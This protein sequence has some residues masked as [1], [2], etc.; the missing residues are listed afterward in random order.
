[1]AN[2]GS[3]TKSAAFGNVTLSWNVTSQDVYT[4]K[5]VVA[6]KLTIYRSSNISSSAPK[7]YSITFNDTVVKSGTNTIG[8]SGTKTLAEGSVTLTHLDNGTCS[9]TFGFSQDIEI[10]WSGKWNG[11]LTASGYDTL[12]RLYTPTVPILSA[13]TIEMG[14]NLTI[15][16]NRDSPFYTHMLQYTW[17]SQL[18]NVNIADGV[19]TSYV[20]TIPMDFANYI[21]NGTSGTCILRVYTYEGNMLIGVNTVSF[22]ATVPAS[23]KP[24]ISSV[25]LS[26]TGSNVAVGWGV[27]VQS[28]SKLHVKVA[29][30][31]AYSSRI[32][33]YQISALGISTATNDS[34][35][36]VILSSGS[37]K[38][39]IT[40]T[41]S[42]GRTATASRTI[43]VEAYEDP[44]IETATIERANNTGTPIDNGTFAK[45]KLKA[46]G[47]SVSGNN[48]VQAKVY[49]MRS[50]AESWTLARTILV[51]YSFDDIVMIGNME[52]SR[53]YAYKIELT[54][55]FGTT[56]AELTLR[57]EGAVVGW[58]AG[59]IGVSFG[60]AA[61]ESY[62]ADF[63]WKIHGRQGA[64]I[65]GA[66][67]AD[68]IKVNGI[69]TLQ[70]LDIL[71]VYRGTNVQ[72]GVS[73][74][75]VSI[76]FSKIVYSLNG[77]LTISGG[78]V[79][80][81]EGVRA[82]KV[83]AQVCLGADTAGARYVQV[84]KN[85]F[86]DTLARSQKQHASTSV[87]ETHVIAGALAL[88]N[89][90]D[91]IL[92]GVYG[93]TSD[94]IYGNFNQTYLTVEAYA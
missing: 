70:L 85:A 9:F 17:G 78:G 3:L 40:V 16:L 72:L 47:S 35:I 60:K 42:R 25:T 33:V 38:V 2:S 74:S 41:D 19:G 52:P 18:V 76:D 30:S 77:L 22:T 23:V 93:N 56:L 34:D 29:A 32:V 65:D 21:Q 81:P 10:T 1:M 11:T 61:E 39:D 63:D 73:S 6:F 28:K 50:D 57:A 90:G 75:Y 44:V 64:K 68:V 62:T 7:D 43:D 14:Q 87:P 79:L 84:S 5:S 83:S 80:I 13:S 88:V 36:G 24:T 59:G 86:S 49:H 12:N 91:I 89:A 45:I 82:V 48:T 66:I 8:G 37:V 51:A 58:M 27:W 46:T 15:T 55:A 31:G 92:V 54:D 20:W 69:Q 67:D 94:W 53:S 26:D 4:K 71:S